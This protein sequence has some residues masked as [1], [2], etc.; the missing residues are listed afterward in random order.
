LLFFYDVTNRTRPLADT[1]YIGFRWESPGT[2]GPARFHGA[3]G[4]IPKGTELTND[5][6]LFD[7]VLC[8]AFLK[9]KVPAPGTG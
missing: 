6:R 9:K 4:D 5:Y 2:P 3:T 7:P 8:A 1:N